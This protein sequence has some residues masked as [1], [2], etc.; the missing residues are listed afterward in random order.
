MTVS[1]LA[2]QEYKSEGRREQFWQE[3]SLKNIKETVM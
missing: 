1:L 2:F 3:A